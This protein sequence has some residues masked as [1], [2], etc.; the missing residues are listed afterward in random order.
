[1][2][3]GY[4]QHRQSELN[5]FSKYLTRRAKSSCELCGA[6]K[7]SL[8]IFEVPPTPDEPEF[9]HCVYLCSVCNKQFEDPRF[10]DSTHWRCLHNA[11]WSE[12]P[13][14][15]V[16]A[17][18]QLKLLSGRDWADELNEGLYLMPEVESWLSRI[19]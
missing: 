3:R 5:H 14:V 10:F 1:M 19:H 15:Q 7:T 6:Q 13:A 16:M 11:V 4:A 12:V 2:T 17:I 9:E 8:T 18:M